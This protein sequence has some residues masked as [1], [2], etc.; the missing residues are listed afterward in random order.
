MASAGTLAALIPPS[1][2]FVL[3]GIFAE[4]SIVKLLIAGIIP[5]L[6]TARSTRS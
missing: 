6:L 3:Y 4:V 2:L 1:I 5:G